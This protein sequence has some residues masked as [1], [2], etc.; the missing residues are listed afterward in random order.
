[1][2]RFKGEPETAFQRNSL[3]AIELV[4]A[5]TMERVS[6]GVKV[7]GEGLPKP[8]V[9]GGGLFVWPGIEADFAKLRGI[10]IDPD[11]L[12]YEKVELKPADVLRPLMTVQLRP[13][14][15]YPFA[16]GI[17][18]IRGALIEELPPRPRVPVPHA[19]VFLRWLDEHGVWREAPTI[20]RTETN[21]DFAAIVRLAPDDLP[22]LDPKGAM[23]V[24]LRVRRNFN[25]RGTAD[26]K[27]AQGRIADA[28]TFAWDE[29][30]P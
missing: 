20:S 10:S 14:V 18:G 29:L 23:T 19:D 9:N 22:L 8:I 28:L 16:A 17:T 30:R 21:G 15:S 27:L 7:A 24:R 2:S 5:V 25:E 6:D 13:R 11:L 26:M 4:D 12:P 1:V 3:F